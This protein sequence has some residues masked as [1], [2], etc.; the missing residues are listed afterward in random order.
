MKILAI[1]TSSVNC[2]VAILEDKNLII[3][4]NSNDEKTHSQKLLPLIDLTLSESNISLNEINLI[5]CCIGPGS[6]TGIRIGV[7]TV[8]AF[9]DATN[10]P[11]I[12]I[13]SLESLAY[14]INNT[15]LIV[16]LIDAKNDN[17]YFSLHEHDKNGKY[18]LVLDYSADTIENIL[19][20]LEQFSNKTLIFVGDGSVIH[21]EIINSK[22]NNIIFSA[23][24][25]NMQNSFSLGKIGFDKHL[26]GLSGNSNS[27]S[28]IYLKKSQAE[29]ALNGEK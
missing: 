27:I 13:T 24:K 21:K 29:R 15:G 20:K 19:K 12:G 10:I 5:S 8:K 6:F 25:E 26:T 22:F 2:S 28:P 16:S 17:V 3:E 1:D 14:N 18:N 9:A 4:K 11:I 7:S 23:E